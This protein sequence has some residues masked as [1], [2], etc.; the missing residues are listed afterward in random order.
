ME[1]KRFLTFSEIFKIGN[2]NLLTTNDYKV[3][4]LSLVNNTPDEINDVVTEMHKRLNG[5]WVETD[6]IANL[7]KRYWEINAFPDMPKFECKIGS[8]FL[9]ENIDLLN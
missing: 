3:K 8:K 5:E 1:K 2:E 7:Q 6:E 9:K 4:N